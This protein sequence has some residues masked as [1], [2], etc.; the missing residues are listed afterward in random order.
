MAFDALE[1][2]RQ[3]ELAASRKI[4]E[5]EQS[6]VEAIKI[7]K[8]KSEAMINTAE[9]EVEAMVA[10][11]AEKAEA[12]ADEIFVTAYNSALLEVDKLRTICIER[13]SEV[14]ECVIDL[15]I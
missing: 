13:Q 2:V 9:Q 6:A 11:S 15:L 5:A 10:L 7:A 14:N 3:A 8:V 4:E 1:I 12:I